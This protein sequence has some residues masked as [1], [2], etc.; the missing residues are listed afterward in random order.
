MMR[1]A[2]TETYIVS[3]C[4]WPGHSDWSI[5]HP[6]WRS[7]EPSLPLQRYCSDVASARA[8]ECG[9]RR[10]PQTPLRVAERP[11]APPWA[12]MPTHVHGHHADEVHVDVVRG[13]VLVGAALQLLPVVQDPQDLRG[14][15]TAQCVGGWFVGS[16]LPAASHRTA[17]ST[18][19][20]GGRNDAIA[21]V[22]RRQCLGI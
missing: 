13:V 21:S 9:M 5:G 1:G 12:P 14:G 11:K 2:K 15:D 8:G 10:H 18:G 4:H 16:S 20:V 7:P 6:G 3:S 22:C 17:T 19:S